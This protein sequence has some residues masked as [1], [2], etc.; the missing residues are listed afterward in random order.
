MNEQ[1]AMPAVEPR[2]VSL[3]SEL[4]AIDSQSPTPGESKV[5]AFVDDHCRRMGFESAV[6]ETAP[7]RCCVLAS[8]EAGSGPTLG[9]SGHLDTKHLG[10]SGADWS[11][12]PHELVIDGDLAYGLGTSDMKAG[13]AAMLLAAERWSTC[14]SGGRLDLVFTADEETGGHL[15]ARL[16]AERG[17]ITCDA[18]VVGE[19]SRRE[20][21]WDAVVTVSRGAAKFEVHIDGTRGH[22]SLSPIL[23]TSATVAA[24][25]VVIALDE[26][27]ADEITRRAQQHHP[28]TVNA[29]ITLSGGV[30]YGV[31]PGTASLACEIRLPTGVSKPTVESCVTSILDEAV[32]ADVVCRWSFLPGLTGWKDAV[33][34]DPGH[35]LVS[36]ATDVL[37]DVAA[38]V[39][40]LAACPGGTDA[41]W[42]ATA[43]IPAIA[44]LG[45]GDLAV[46]HAPNEY[47]RLS[48]LADAQEIYF[49]IAHRYLT[50]DE[51]VHA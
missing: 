21:A 31:H 2:A 4:V 39:P 51:D 6:V 47:V 41:N 48:E 7:G 49:S 42:F 24:A 13:I 45:P 9:F 1:T 25:R 33:E 16:L 14:A 32:P 17:L 44:A 43:G 12:P 28:V 19:P 3:L 36:V 18:L 38:A 46:A 40:E 23:P 10:T 50:P 29:G 11:T 34:I 20:R 37:T 5:A 26:H 30:G 27:L 35:R 22:S 8:C 15:G